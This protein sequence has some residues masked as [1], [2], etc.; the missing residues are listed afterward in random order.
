MSQ[1]YTTDAGKLFGRQYLLQITDPTKPD[2]PTNTLDIT[3]LDISFNITLSKKH[4][5]N[6]GEFRIYNLRDSTFREQHTIRTGK[7]LTLSVGYEGLLKSS[8]GVEEGYRTVPAESSA[9]A[10]TDWMKTGVIF[11]G[12]IRSV[13]F[14]HE[15]ADWCTKVECAEGSKKYYTD[16]VSVSRA[17]GSTKKQVLRAII[18]EAGWA[19]DSRI[20]R[21]LSLPGF[22]K[23][24]EKYN[25]G[26]SFFGRASE[27]LTKLLSVNGY[28][29]SFQ[30]DELTILPKKGYVLE[31]MVLITS[32]S[33]LIGSPES[34]SAQKIG[35][36]L[37][38]KGAGSKK[39]NK[40][41]NLVKFKSLILPTLR[42]GRKV[43]LESIHYERST[44]VLNKVTIDGNTWGEEWTATCEGEIIG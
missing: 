31:E 26:Y 35:G 24:D 38:K 27:A 19:T 40:K 3:G 12:D 1:G 15:G 29:W 2:S 18:L 42:P 22:E 10:L 25:Q 33:G 4:E 20:S 44:V 37:Q 17:G 32:S 21:I 30:G 23:L 8:S 16:F 41:A 36:L 13:D 5:P 43:E 28:S 39:L 6:P 11:Q 34:T 9:P 7:L 14:I